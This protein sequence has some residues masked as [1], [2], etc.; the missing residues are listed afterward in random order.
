MSIIHEALKKVQQSLGKTSPPEDHVEILPSN[1]NPDGTSPAEAPP[2]LPS[3]A[4]PSPA[5]YPIFLVPLLLVIVF[6]CL[7][8]IASQVP[9]PF[10]RIKDEIKFTFYKIKRHASTPIAL[11]ST[12]QPLAKVAPAANG[13]TPGNTPDAQTLNIQGVMANGAN[14]VVLIN[15]KIMEEGAFVGGV[16]ILKINL[17]AITILNNGKEEIIPVRP[18]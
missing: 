13:Q 10:N 2:P 15:N 7:A 3:S 16:Q 17:D 11:K 18:N 5:A 8:Y 12:A 4:K 14:N 1:P 6:A 9:A